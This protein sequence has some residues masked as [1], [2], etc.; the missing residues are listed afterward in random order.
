MTDDDSTGLDTA[1]SV[2][3]AKLPEETRLIVEGIMEE[4]AAKGYGGWTGMSSSVTHAT[5][6]SRP[7]PNSAPWIRSSRRRYPTTRR[8]MTIYPSSTRN[9]GR[10]RSGRDGASVISDFSPEF[11]PLWA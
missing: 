6:T 1:I 10:S 9:A 4:A 3:L 11:P 5:A 7:R 8:S 2:V